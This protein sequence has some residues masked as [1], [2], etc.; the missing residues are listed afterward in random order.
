MPVYKDTQRGTWYY[1]IRYRDSTGRV[2]SIK[3]RGFETKVIAERA[4]R[5]RLREHQYQDMPVSQRTMQEVGYEMLDEQS[6]NILPETLDLKRKR[7]EMYIPNKPIG[8][9]SMQRSIKWRN[10]LDKVTKLNGEKISVTYKNMLIQLYKAIIKYALAYD[11]INADPTLRMELYKRTSKDNLNYNVPSPEKFFTA[12][13][14]LKEST[15]N[16]IW[17]KMLVLIAYSGGLSRAEI[18]GLKGKDFKRSKLDIYE[19]ITGKNKEDRNKVGATKKPSRVRVVTLDD[20]TNVE[21][22]RLK[23]ILI[24]INMYDDNKLLIGF[25][26]SLPNNTIQN[27]FKAMNLECRFHDLRH[28]HTTLLI[29]NNVPIN[30]VAKRL[31]HGSVITTLNVYTHA[32]KTDDDEATNVFNNI[33]KNLI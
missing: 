6:T 1:D 19:T 24:S 33:T 27:N 3:R 5:K 21:L 7:I 28:A 31:G 23:N 16:N 13:G 18:K 15:V 22:E 11:Y 20:S 8:T 14:Q 29:E 4:E 30:L 12:Y 32:I 9:L 2:R 10:D 17:F 25:N 26:S